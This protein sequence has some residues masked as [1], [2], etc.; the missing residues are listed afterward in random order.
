MFV[1]GHIGIGRLI[2]GPR[3]R[4]LPV[5]PF[6]FGTVLPDLIDKPMYYS[7][8]W[9]FVSCTRTFGHTGLFLLSLAAVAWIRR[10]RAWGAVALAVATHLILDRVLDLQSRGTSSVWIA[11]TWPFLYSHFAQYDLR[12]SDHIRMFW[13]PDIFITEMIGLFLI[14]R[15]YLKRRAT[16]VPLR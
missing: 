14:V 7:G 8:V 1:L 9:E 13:R 12:V 6:V 16:G 3:G 4:A 10:S 15:E 11:F 2:V 5:A